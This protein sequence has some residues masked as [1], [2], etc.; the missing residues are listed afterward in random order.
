MPESKT[1]VANRRRAA[2]HILPVLGDT[3]VDS[4]TRPMLEGWLAAMVKGETPEAIRA[5]RA[6]ANRVRTILNAAL[7]Q[8]FKND[9]CASDR[10]WK[11][12]SPFT[13]P[14]ESFAA[15]TADGIYLLEVKT[16]YVAR[17]L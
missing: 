15:A 2:R 1:V 5:S 14:G 3:P 9:L 6:S 12:T 10:A 4:L 13:D 8:A 17:P 11:A 7:N 16:E